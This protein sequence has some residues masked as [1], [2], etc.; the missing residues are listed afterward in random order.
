M[1]RIYKDNNN[2]INRLKNE[3]NRKKIYIY[4][5]KNKINYI[6]ISYN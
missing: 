2:N 6:I 5:S 3:I 1:N 4:I